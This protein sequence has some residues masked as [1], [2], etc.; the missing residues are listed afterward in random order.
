MATV[1]ISRGNT[2]P[3]SASKADFHNLV[4]QASITVTGI[5]NADVSASAAIAASKLDLATIG[6]NMAMSSKIFKFA[7]GADVASAS[8]VTLGD[9]GNFF[10]ITG[11]TGITSITAKTAGTVVMLQFDGALTVT[12]GSNLTLDGNFTTAAGSTLLLVCD[13]TNWYELARTPNAVNGT[14]HPTIHV[15]K[16]GTNQTGVAASTLTKVTFSTET[17]DT[18]GNFD[19]GT[20]RFTPTVAGKYYVH[21]QIYFG[22][23]GS[24]GFIYDSAIYKNGSLV[25]RSRNESS[26]DDSVTSEVS[27]ILDLDGDDYVEIYFYHELSGATTISG[28]ESLTYFEAMRVA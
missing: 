26:G 8:T 28:A 22:G 12:D 20:S 4:D 17:F 13:G 2:L 27:A 16:N 25:K 9:D 5:V 18:N 19:T 11:T 14:N 21:A 10:D 7:K 6:Q 23:T 1:T 24:A 15:H 3:D